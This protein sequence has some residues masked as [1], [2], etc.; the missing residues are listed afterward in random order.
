MKEKIE[1]IG[2]FTNKQKWEIYEVHKL[3]NHKY[4]VWVYSIAWEFFREDTLSKNWYKKFLLDNKI[5]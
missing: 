1:I 2:K 4:T 3:S 5:L